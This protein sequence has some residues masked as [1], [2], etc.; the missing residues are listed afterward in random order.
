MSG[1][2][3]RQHS[4]EHILTSVFNNLFGGKLIDTRFK[5]PKVR[6]DFELKNN[7]DLEKIIQD[8]EKKVNKIISEKLNVEFEECD[9]EEAQKNFSLHRLP[10]GLEKIRIVKIGDNVVIPCSGEH[11]E[12]TSEIGIL[13]IRT[14]KYVKPG[15]L[16]LTFG[17]E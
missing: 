17:I 6:C 4:A 13:K 10:E 3:S 8:V 16:R 9:C 15:V 1:V 5:S 2:Y 12:N 14:Y 11:V 7:N